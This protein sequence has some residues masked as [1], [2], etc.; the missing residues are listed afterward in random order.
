MLQEKKQEKCKPSKHVVIMIIAM[1]M[2]SQM[3]WQTWLLRMKAKTQVRY[4]ISLIF[5]NLRNYFSKSNVKYVASKKL[6]LDLG[7]NN[8]ELH[9]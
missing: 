3:K 4:E 1:K 7:A 2:K 5:N 6:I 9:K 8:F